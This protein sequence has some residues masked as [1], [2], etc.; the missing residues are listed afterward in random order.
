MRGRLTC[1]DVFKKKNI[2]KCKVLRR[3]EITYTPLEWI[4]DNVNAIS[5]Y[6]ILRNAT[7]HMHKK[8]DVFM[9]MYV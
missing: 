2:V 8:K 7:A 1:D 6:S 3:I 9:K 5:Y 4:H